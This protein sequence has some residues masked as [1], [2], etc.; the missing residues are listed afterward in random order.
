MKME[1]GEDRLLTAAELA[2]ALAVSVS[3]IRR[4]SRDRQVPVVRV[5]TL[6]RYDLAAVVEALGRFS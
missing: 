5:R 1:N 4:M 3:T 6:V 2:D